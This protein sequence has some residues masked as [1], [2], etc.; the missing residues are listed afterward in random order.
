MQHQLAFSPDRCPLTSDSA[1]RIPDVGQVTKLR[2]G[3]SLADAVAVSSDGH[4]VATGSRDK[5]VVVWEVSSGREMARFEFGV[6]VNRVA[7]SPDNELLAAAGS[8]RTARIWKYPIRPGTRAP[9]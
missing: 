7:F 1:L 5:S 9:T 6:N 2:T 4:Y 3:S 8:D